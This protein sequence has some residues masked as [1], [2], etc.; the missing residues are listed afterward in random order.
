MKNGKTAT[1]VKTLPLRRLFVFLICSFLCFGLIAPAL[2]AP[3]SV[4]AAGAGTLK[5]F[6]IGMCAL[7]GVGNI[8]ADSV[9]YLNNNTVLNAPIEDFVGDNPIYTAA[10][11]NQALA[12]NEGVARWTAGFANN[13]ANV[14]VA[15]EYITSA[16]GDP[17]GLNGAGAASA[18]ENIIS[19]MRFGYNNYKTNGNWDLRPSIGGQTMTDALNST[20]VMA[21][22]S[23]YAYNFDQYMEY[24]EQAG[25]TQEERNELWDQG[26]V[27]AD[28]NQIEDYLQNRNKTIVTGND[29]NINNAILDIQPFGTHAF[30]YVTNNGIDVF[31]RFM[32]SNQIAFVYKNGSSYY[33]NYLSEFADTQSL[34]AHYVTTTGKITQSYYSI[35]KTVNGYNFYTATSTNASNYMNSINI[36]SIFNSLNDAYEWF[37]TN[38]NNIVGESPSLIG[39]NGQLSGTSQTD[40]VTNAPVYN[41]N[42]S[43]TANY[44][45]NNYGLPSDED[46]ATYIS[47]VQTAIEQG[48]TQENIGTIFQNFVQSMTYEAPAEPM[49]TSAPVVPVQPTVAPKPTLTPEQETQNTEI[50]GTEE[51]KDKF[52][53]CIPWD[54][55]AFLT[56]LQAEPEAP[57][58]HGTID[59]GIAGEHEI[60]LDLSDYDEAAAIFRLVELIAFIVGLALV[61]RSLIGAGGK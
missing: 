46:I 15:Q 21:A 31:Y 23:N 27:F 6:I 22:M 18:G 32:K 24:A 44:V 28:Q 47:D 16:G 7:M 9:S 58:I 55:A 39:N 8:N 53:F 61:T 38:N 54:I 10:D 17:S 40:P 5:A 34:S 20:A 13:A 56:A 52:P 12:S 60:N 33:I 37:N 42:V 59:L 50:M 57:S 48:D 11:I 36:N 51:L 29:I 43:P 41:I 26:L 35:N 1:A 2:I 30:K 14:K 4:Y 49:P 45:T 19:S 25:L 3:V